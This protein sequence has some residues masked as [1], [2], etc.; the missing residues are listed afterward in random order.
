MI[1]HCVYHYGEREIS[2]QYDR[3]KK[4]W[5]IL[6]NGNEEL[7]MLLARFNVNEANLRFDDQIPEIIRRFDDYFASQHRTIDHDHLKLIVAPRSRQEST[8]SSIRCTSSVVSSSLLKMKVMFLFSHRFLPASRSGRR[9]IQSIVLDVRRKY[10]LTCLS[11]SRSKM[12]LEQRSSS[13][14]LFFV[15]LE[16]SSTGRTLLVGLRRKIQLSCRSSSKKRIRSWCRD[17]IWLFSL[18][19]PSRERCGC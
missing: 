13:I 6:S 17:S 1:Y 8:S 18:L 5:S 16:D 3:S 12:S 14:P 7:E 10:A 9:M 4:K 19:F 2:L 15:F 11:L